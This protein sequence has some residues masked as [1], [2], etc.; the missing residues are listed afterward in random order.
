MPVVAVTLP[1]GGHNFHVWYAAS[2][3]AF[4]WLG[5]HLLGAATSSPTA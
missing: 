5:A 1:S 4:P 2:L 3:E